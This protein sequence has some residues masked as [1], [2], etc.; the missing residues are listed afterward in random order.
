MTVPMPVDPTSPALAQH[1]AEARRIGQRGWMVIVL[2]VLPLGA[3]MVTAPL[4]SAVIAPAFVKVDLERRPVQ[5]TEGGVVR[6]VRVRDGQRVAQG[7]TLMVLGDV[8]VDADADR[9]QYRVWAERAGVARLEAE[10]A[11]AARVSFPDD[12][13]QAAQEDARVKA[14]LTKE[15]AL[16]EVRRSALIER[17]RLLSEQRAQVVQEAAGLRAQIERANESLRLQQLDLDNQASLL[18]DGF[19]ASTRV[20]QLQAN[21]ADYG[22]KLEERRAELARAQQR[23]LDTELRARALEGDYRQQASDQLKVASVR[24]AEIQQELRKATDAAS[25]QQIKAPAAGEV[26]NMKVTA[27]GAVLAPRETV[28]DILPEQ[29]RLVIETHVRPEDV[30]QVYRGQAA[31]VRFPAFNHRSTP[32]VDGHVAYVAADRTLDRSNNLAYYVVLV[33]ADADSLARAGGLRLQAGMPAE[34]YLRGASRTPLRYLLDPLT[35]GLQRAARE[36]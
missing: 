30:A 27:A 9:L 16:F 11:G 10:Q 8:A 33:E 24:L 21:V 1:E 28:A 36:R 2:A 25:R 32:M 17:V 13:L 35:Q 7:E 23:L 15:Q 22:V 12:L 34:V 26:M 5:H 4:A 18:K 3:W 6:E 19:I 14:Q 29:P 20:A 31:E